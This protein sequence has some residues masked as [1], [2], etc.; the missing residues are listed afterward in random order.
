MRV[1]CYVFM[2]VVT[3]GFAGKIRA[4]TDPAPIPLVA[5]EGRLSES[6]TL[7]NG[8]RSFVFTIVDSSGNQ[9][10]NSGTQG[11]TVTG[12]LYG[13]ILGGGGMP[14]LPGSLMGR[15]NLNLRVNID[16]VQ[17][18]PDVPLIPALQAITAWNVG[19]PFLGDI[20]GRQQLISVDKLKGI[21]IDIAKAPIPGEV[22]TFSGSSWIASSPL[23]GPQGPQ[24]AIGPSGPA[25][26]QGLVGPIGP[27]G[28]VGPQGVAG[29]GASPGVNVKDYGAKGDGATDD[30]AAI[31]A[32]LSAAPL[33][34]VVYFP[35]GTYVV[36]PATPFTPHSG[37]TILGTSMHCSM[38]RYAGS[39]QNQTL[40][41]LVYNDASNYG[42]QI[43][44]QDIMIAGSNTPGTTCVYAGTS[45]NPKTQHITFRDVKI[46]Q[47]DPGIKTG[48]VWFLVVDNSLLEWNYGS[49]FE[50]AEPNAVT[51][52][53]FENGTRIG[54]NGGNGIVHDGKGTVTQLVVRDSEVSY[55]GKTEIVTGNAR[56]VAIESVWLEEDTTPRD[57]IDV[58]GCISCTVN[59]V[60]SYRACRG[61]VS[62][63]TSQDLRIQKN[64]FTSPL[65]SPILLQSGSTGEVTNNRSDGPLQLPAS[66]TSNLNDAPAL[67]TTNTPLTTAC[68]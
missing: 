14:P 62:S 35:C 34:G 58:T 60:H 26:P 49:A 50:F 20:S 54:N 7:A 18:S 44:F 64:S 21:P 27:V 57:G 47:C 63:T 8:V 9:L 33:G 52:A 40:F 56:D 51:G 45:G 12:G 3:L 68:P 59:E 24:G 17:L 19:G 31:V 46:T 37:T 30:T 32:A 65:N 28:P 4:Q 10:W 11:V 29:P 2:L 67:T 36:K 13:I 38:I 43:R 53:F 22:L 55:N 41:S 23:A 42:S 39:A 1:A 16:G 66:M 5:Y 6:N 48:D 61:V 25:G 15:T